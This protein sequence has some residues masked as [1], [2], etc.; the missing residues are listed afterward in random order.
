MAIW[1]IVAAPLIMVSCMMLFVGIP[2]RMSVCEALC[3]GACVC[4]RVWAD[5][6]PLFMV[7][8]PGWYVRWLVCE[9]VCFGG[10]CVGACPCGCGL[11]V[12]CAREGDDCFVRGCVVCVR[13][14]CVSVRVWT[15][16]VLR[17]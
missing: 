2:V 5:V 9:G 16:G 4:V 15:V 10:A 3:T 11:Q 6:A 12:C 1:S 17:M 13:F 8:V 7:S 14:G